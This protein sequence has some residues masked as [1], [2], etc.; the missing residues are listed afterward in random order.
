MFSLTST[1]SLSSFSIDTLSDVDTSS[2]APTNGQALVW[3]NSTSVWEPGT[4]A[5]GASANTTN[6]A[7]ST[8]TT[9]TTDNAENY[10]VATSAMT[11]TLPTPS[12]SNVGKKIILKSYTT[13]QTVIASASGS[14][15]IYDSAS[16]VASITQSSG[17]P[18]FCTS[19]ICLQIGSGT[20][21]WVVI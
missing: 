5:T 6:C 20:Y 1:V 8:N 9:A 7:V 15:I 18:G 21:F 16:P 10:F 4:V 14:Q 19:L 3:N 17:F 13:G 12:S 2:V 11:L